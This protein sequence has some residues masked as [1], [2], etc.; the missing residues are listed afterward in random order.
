[1]TRPPKSQPGFLWRSISACPESVN[2]SPSGL[3]ETPPRK[4]SLSLVRELP[5]GSIAYVYVAHTPDASDR[6]RADRSHHEADVHRQGRSIV[7]GKIG[8]M[9]GERRAD[10]QGVRESRAQADHVVPG[11]EGPVVGIGEA[12]ADV[13]ARDAGRELGEAVVPV[14]S[15]EQARRGSP[16]REPRGI[17]EERS[18]VIDVRDEA[19][20]GELAAERRPDGR[21]RI[22]RGARRRAGERCIRH[23]RKRHEENGKTELFHRCLLY[24]CRG[25]F[26]CPLYGGHCIRVAG[27][28]NRK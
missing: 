1:M 10:T 14:R 11:N 13:L 8:V 25:S 17:H 12:D 26:V 20:R 16:H 5:N 28:G 24:E 7:I 21:E 22:D 3:I 4:D 23:K 6:E 18:G 15:L 9:P 2:R 27:G 19:V